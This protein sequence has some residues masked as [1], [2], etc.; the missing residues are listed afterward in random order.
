MEF[1]YI[2]EDEF[3]EGW[4]VIQKSS[5]VLFDFMDVKE[6]PLHHVWTIVES[7]VHGD[8]LYA[9]PGFHYVNRVGYV[10]TRVPWRLESRDA[11]YFNGANS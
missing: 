7:G 4:G 10:I 2:S 6:L 9:M 1:G 3:W 11:I 5:G 8:R